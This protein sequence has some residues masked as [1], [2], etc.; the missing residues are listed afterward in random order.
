M[1]TAIICEKRK[2][3]D[4]TK[5]VIKEVIEYEIEGKCYFGRVPLSS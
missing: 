3:L 4:K 2:S 5:F 1:I